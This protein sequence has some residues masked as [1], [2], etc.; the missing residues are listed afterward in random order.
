[1][2]ILFSRRG[3]LQVLL[4]WGS[5]R[6]QGR[7]YW[8][9]APSFQQHSCIFCCFIRQSVGDY[10]ELFE[11]RIPQPQK[12]ESCSDRASA[13]WRQSPCF[14]P[15]RLS[16][17]FCWMESQQKSEA[18]KGSSPNTEAVFHRDADSQ[19]LIVHQRWLLWLQKLPMQHGNNYIKMQ[20]EIPVISLE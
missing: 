19:P 13:C 9:S 20:L 8:N 7:D 1:M 11:G 12:H 3:P 10:V 17:N 5:L 15:S 6:G 16:V 18:L 14:A 4:R 2:C